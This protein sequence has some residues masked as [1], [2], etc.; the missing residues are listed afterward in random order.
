MLKMKVDPEMY[1]KTKDQD[2][3]LPDTKDDICAWLH[4]IL[5]RN[6]CILRQPSALLPLFGALENE[7]VASNKWN[8]RFDMS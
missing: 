1:M 4:A 6:T 3:N 5:H 7:P 8:L 2:D